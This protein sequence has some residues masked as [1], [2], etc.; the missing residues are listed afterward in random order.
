MKNEKALFI[1]SIIVTVLF[2]ACIFGGIIYFRSNGKALDTVRLIQEQDK[3]LAE[4]L[5]ASQASHAII[6]GIVKSATATVGAIAGG[7]DSAESAIDASLRIAGK[8]LTFIDELEQA[9]GIYANRVYS[10]TNI[11][12]GG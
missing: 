7:I 10:E 6:T 8:F 4:E 1:Y 5:A 9:I 12:S 2:V 3:Q 11:D